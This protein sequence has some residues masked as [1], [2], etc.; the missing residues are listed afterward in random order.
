M[1]PPGALTTAQRLA[2]HQQTLPDAQ[3]AAAVMRKTRQRRAGGLRMLR[4]SGGKRN[5]VT[6]VQCDNHS[7]RLIWTYPAVQHFYTSRTSWRKCNFS[8]S[9]PNAPADCLAPL[10]PQRS[11]GLRD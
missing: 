3:S 2:T 1:H 9:R 8:A 6:M 11:C 7:L 10:D 5:L 4:L